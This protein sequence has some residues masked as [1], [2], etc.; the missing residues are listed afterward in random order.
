MVS[1]EVIEKNDFSLN[2]SRYIDSQEVEDLQ[3]IEGHLKGSIP[4]PDID[5]LGPYWTICPNLRQILRA[6]DARKPGRR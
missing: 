3:D 5:A 4:T 1:V 6:Q 2:L